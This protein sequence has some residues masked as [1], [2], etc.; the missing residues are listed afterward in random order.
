MGRLAGIGVFIGGA[1]AGYL[2]SMVALY[3]LFVSLNGGRDMNGGVAMS[4]AFFIGPTCQRV[5]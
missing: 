5:A 1:V 2:F 4:V 3:P